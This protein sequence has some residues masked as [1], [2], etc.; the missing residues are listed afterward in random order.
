MFENIKRILHFIFF[1]RP[2]I[3]N[4]EV[5]VYFDDIQNSRTLLAEYTKNDPT[6]AP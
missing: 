2:F 4:I 3:S 6:P 1:K 5:S